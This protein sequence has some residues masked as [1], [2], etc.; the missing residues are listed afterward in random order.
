M[1]GKL[2][3]GALALTLGACAPLATPS[4]MG[5]PAEVERVIDG[6]TLTA[7]TADGQQLT[8]RIIGVDAPER[9]ACYGA[10]ATAWLRER[11]GDR[12][13]ILS[14]PE[15]DDDPYGR[16]LRHVTYDRELVA[17]AAV[18]A[19]MARVATYP[20]NDRHADALADAERDAR[21]DGRG[22]WGAC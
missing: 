11:V 5:E 1:R 21:E 9:G 22:L 13:V 7:E 14:P 17:L 12:V 3:S 15:R 6:D 8:V 19:G 4:D 10:Q 20:P 2:A 18:R 16:A